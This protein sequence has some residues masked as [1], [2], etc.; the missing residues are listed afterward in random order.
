[1]IGYGR[2]ESRDRAG[3]GMV[4][5]DTIRQ[6]RISKERK[7]KGRDRRGYMIG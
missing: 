3:M 1:M 5:E 2:H 4:E 6:G 7:R